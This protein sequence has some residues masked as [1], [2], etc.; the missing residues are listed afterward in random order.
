MPDLFWTQNPALC[1]RPSASDSLSDIVHHYAAQLHRR[2]GISYH[3][4]QLWVLA[5]MV[6]LESEKE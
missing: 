3:D 2:G 4:A 1:R 5:Q 6:R